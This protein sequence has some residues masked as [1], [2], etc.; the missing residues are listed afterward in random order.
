[1]I[2]EKVGVWVLGV[3]FLLVCFG[4]LIQS[5]PMS[6]Q[7]LGS[8]ALNGSVTDSSGAVVPSATVTLTDPATKFTR[9]NPT[10]ESG[11]YTFSNLTPGLY[12]LSVEARGFKKTVVKGVQLFVGQAVVEN[13]QLEVGP[14]TQEVSVTAA[15]PLLKVNTAET[16]TV[17]EPKMITEIPLNGRNFLQLNLLAPGVTRSKNSNTFDATQIDP[18]THSFN[19]NGQHG[20]YNKYLL[21]GTTIKEYTSGGISFSPSIDAVQEFEVATSNYSADLGSEAGAQVNVATKSGTNALHG[22]AYEFLRNNKF[23]A[24]D[25]FSPLVSPFKQN[26]FGAT[27]GGPVIIP[28][29]YDGRNRTFFF[30][31]YEGFRQVKEVPQ[32]GNYPTPGQLQGDLST[33]ITPGKPLIDPLTGQPFAD[34]KIPQDRMPSTL[35][36]FLENGIGKGPWIPTPNYSRP[37]IDYFRPDVQRFSNNQIIVRGDQRIGNGTFLYARY[38]FNNPIKRDPN[39]SPQWFTDEKEPAQSVAGHVAHSFG[40]NLLW[41]FTFGFSKFRYE[42]IYSTNFNNDITNSILKIKGYPTFPSSWGVP[43]WGVAGYSDLGEM[44]AAPRAWAA[45][46]LEFR[47]GVTKIIGKHS[48]RFGG[49][50]DRF[51]S[52]FPE[53]IEGS[54]S[55]DGRFTGYAL[56]DFLLGYPSGTFS[57]PSPFDP[58]TRYSGIAG[59]FQDDWKATS[60]LTLNLGVR[61]EWSGIPLSANRSIANWYLGPNNAPPVLVVSDNP[62]PITFEGQTQA[63]YTGIPYVQASK[64][65]L[66]EAL[67]FSDTKDL[68]PRLGFAYSLPGLSNSVIRGGYG[69]FYQRDIENKWVD[70]A[71]NPPFVEILSAAFDQS[72]FRQFNWFDP[73]SLASASS[74]GA[75]ANDPHLKNG[76]IQAWNL[77][78]E[79]T[80]GNTLFSAAYVGNTSRHLPN[81][82]LPNQAR[83]GPGPIDS[84]RRWPSAGTVNYFN[85][86]SNANYNGLQLK[87]QRP[88]KKGFSLLASYTWSKT[89]DDSGGTFVGEGERQGSMQD[90]YDRRADRGLAPQDIRHRLVLSYIYQI[91]FGRGRPYLNQSR[92]ADAVLGEWQIN[93]ITSFQSGS[94]VLVTQSCNR[95]NT[96]SGTLRPDAIGNPNDLSGGRSSGQLVDKFFDT[97]AY[98]AYCPDPT[99]NGPFNF[100]NAGRN[101]VIGPGLNVWDFGLFKD[102]PIRGEAKRL[103]FRAEF[104]NLANHPIFGQPAATADLPGFGQISYTAID[105]REIQF[106][107]KLYF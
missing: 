107:L 92:L 18:N 74:L 30:G 68:A 62:K 99:G 1:M 93:G 14:V 85:Y 34:N 22:D 39:L 47:S 45:D 29:L 71:L 10:N 67:V 96:D 59:Y 20:D 89:I 69:I 27:I 94:P 64:L 83:P 31:S 15:A 63:L 98:K 70:G 95:A 9:T 87:V 75:F 58:Q 81:S 50:F 88:F 84:R 38:G 26:Q 32:F 106:A 37:G 5:R 55:F 79:H 76:Q 100:G 46:I 53:V 4:L 90:S 25:F 21:D 57:S 91:P 101:V 78:L 6:A 51:L 86:N 73:F 42:N 49:E 7:Q 23:D 82:E 17:I 3:A 12:D 8:S 43:S 61:Y 33:L 40:P 52:T 54:W 13:L 56:G 16:G 80:M 19:V 41:D 44:Y 77:S 35:L 24:R 72:N 36:P 97:S 105:S 103:Q 102:I 2:K 104:F 66:P 65:G 48:M 11:L 60:H 28:K